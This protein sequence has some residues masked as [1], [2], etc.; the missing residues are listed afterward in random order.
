M[1]QVLVTGATG[2]IGLEVAR[3]L[4]RRGITTR[5]LVRRPSRA[6]LLHGLDVEPVQGD[7]TRPAS[8]HRAVEGVDTVIHLAAR[9]TMEPVERLRPTIVDGTR[10]LTQAA[11]DAGVGH[12]VYASSLLAHGAAPP[13]A[14]I[15]AHTPTDPQVGYGVAKVEAEA[16]LDEVTAG[17]AT[18]VA[19]IRLPHV[20]GPGDLLFSRMRRGLLVTPGLGGNLYAHLHI[21]DAARLLVEVAVQGWVGASATA[22]DRPATWRDFFGVVGAH[23][24]R[25]RHLRVPAPVARLGAAVLDALDPRSRPTVL[26]PDAVVGWNLSQ[27]VAPD[28]VW[29]DL[30]LRPQ[31][32]TVASGVPAALDGSLLFRWRHPVDDPS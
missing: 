18:E 22:D 13:G 26:T 6:G 20:Y 12:V 2:L 31:Y 21:E 17:S 28:L 24:A 23:F 4:S 5:A 7:L 29:G 27:P 8:L 14:P 11:V 15:D 30:G 19:S 1:Q 32:E 9:A 3:E 16:V 25:F 10:A